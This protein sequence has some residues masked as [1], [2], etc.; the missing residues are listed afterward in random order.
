MNLAHAFETALALAAAAGFRALPR[1]GS[2]RAGAA[3]GDLARRIGLRRQVAR[4]NLAIA[5]PEKSE[6]ERERIL[7]A[8][9]HELG[10]V[11]SE[12][13][14]LGELSR[15]DSDAF[16][17]IHGVEHLDRAHAAGKGAILMS[18]HYSNFELMAARVGRFHAMD[19]LTRR[20]SNPGVDRWL[21]ARRRE[22]GLGT[23]PSET[24]VRE[25]YAAMRANRFVAMLADQD[26]R[27]HGAF[28]PFF[29][30][31]TSTALGPARI[32]LATGAPI[33]M[34]FVTRGSDRRLTIHLEPPLEIPES[35]TGEAALALTARHTARLEHWIRRRPE[36][37]FWLHRRWK[38]AAPRGA[39]VPAATH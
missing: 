19:V 14:R 4:D 8:H 24:G 26:A 29:G 1:R 35:G 28:V 31:P 38:T 33:I 13:P 17:A 27:G 16:E 15:A 36:L 6:A 12:Y 11:L 7:R 3:A 21:T 39:D 30:R 9:Y 18:G 5:F 10:R 34:G 20:L 22:A 23:I 2:L 25:V 37:W 32:A